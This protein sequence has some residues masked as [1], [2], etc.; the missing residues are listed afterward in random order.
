MA[1]FRMW[2]TALTVALVAS[3]TAT[4]LPAT[5]VP[6]LVE[7]WSG[8]DRYAT[9]AAISQK[10][11]GPGVATVYVAS[12]ERFPDALSVAPVA[13]MQEV[14]L[15]LTR[16]TRLPSAVAAELARLEPKSIVILGGVSAVSHDVETALRTYTS[17]VERW[18]GPNR[19]AT[20]AA[21]SSKNFAPGVATA[22]IA[23][24]ERFPDALTGAPVAG[25][26]DA[27]LLLTSQTSLPSPVAAELARLKPKSIVILGG[28]SAVSRDVETA[29]AKYTASAPTR[30]SGSDR[31]ATSAEIS[32]ENF[33]PGVATVYVA[34]GERFPD[35]LSAAP[36]AGMQE[37]PLLLT[38]QTS[39]PSPVAAELA[40]L[41]PRK[42]VILGG[43]TTV[44]SDI[45]T[46]LAAYVV[47][48]ADTTP[49]GPV[50]GLGATATGTTV[51]L[52]WT[53]PSGDFTGVMVRRAVGL[54][55]P[56]SP[57]SGTLVADTSAGT[58]A[59]TD[60][61]VAS[62]TRYSYAL[63]AH[64]AVPNYSAAATVTVSTRASFIYMCDSVSDVQSGADPSGKA[65]YD[66]LVDRGDTVTLL[67]SSA[68]VPADAASYDALIIGNS[69]QFS[70]DLTAWDAVEI[71]KLAMGVRSP[72]TDFASSS[73]T[74]DP[75][76]VLTWHVDIPTDPLVP[77]GYGAGDV[78]IYATT[79]PQTRWIDA[80]F[81][82]G[83][84]AKVAS[85][86]MTATNKVELSRYDVGQPMKT[87]TATV[88][89]VWFISHPANF[90]ATGWRFW[91]QALEWTV[92]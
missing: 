7:R 87:G 75:V 46:A 48:P 11:F 19:Y 54:T 30:L 25:M 53:N 22:Y 76:T 1:R 58:S 38:R 12:G 29:L 4:A 89:V 49:P 72:A 47:T 14:P 24:G 10:S 23:S 81:L 82:D 9:S 83:A 62:G 67:A 3:I 20:S 34:S 27:P 8:P 17:S 45:E 84:A 63:F 51:T 35:A 40:R 70:T 16:Q 74:V 77:P 52:T 42:I 80:S 59:V 68:P 31:Y 69:V 56:A 41:K 44:S 18:S 92:G 15:L 61:S 79:P 73:P 66:H 28:V 65:V 37:V 57:S 78:T 50:T 39:L 91:D 21:I 2:W 43:V 26:Q 13:G 85:Y 32:A 64:D 71:P 6:D 5:A 60:T 90:N 88:R 55:P 86:S 36:V 33:A